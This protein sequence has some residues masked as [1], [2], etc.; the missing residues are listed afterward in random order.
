M[1]RYLTDKKHVNY[2]L[3]KHTRVTQFILCIILLM[4]VATTQ[5]LNCKRTRIQNTQFPDCIC[6]TPLTLN[7]T[8]FL[9]HLWP[10]IKPN[11]WHTSDLESKS[12]SPDLQWQNADPSKVIIVQ[13]LK[14][15][16]LMVSEKKPMLKGFLKQRNMS[17]ISLE[18]VWNSKTAIYSWSTSHNQQSY[19]VST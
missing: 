9:T 13:S 4:S 19:A 5:Q 1:T 15:L 18:H 10:W 12:R 6:D 7:Q 2:C 3:W 16:A 17:I 8:W 11:F 14:D